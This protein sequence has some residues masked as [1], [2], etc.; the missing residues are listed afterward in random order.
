MMSELVTSLMNLEPTSRF[1]VAVSSAKADIRKNLF[2][3]I[4]KKTDYFITL[5][6]LFYFVVTKRNAK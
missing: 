2:E 3:L 6:T 5:M 1:E 4:K